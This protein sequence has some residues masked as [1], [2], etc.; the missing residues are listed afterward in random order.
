MRIF[1]KKA[2]RRGLK[3]LAVVLLAVSTG[4]VVLEPMEPAFAQSGA[5]SGDNSRSFNPFRPLLRLFGGGRDHRARKKASKPVR[6]VSRPAETPP[7]FAAEPKDPDAGVILVVGDRMARGVGGGLK[8]LLGD[9]PMVRVELLTEDRKGLAG[10]DAPDWDAQ[11]LAKIRGEDVK[12]VVVMMGQHDLGQKFPGDPPV[13]F[14]T[15]AWIGTYRKKVGD[16]VRTVRQERKPLVWVGL[17]P[18]NAE[19][20]NTDFSQLN[21]IFKDELS[22]SRTWYV[23]IWD[24]FLNEEGGYSSYGPNVDGKNARLRSGDKIGFTWAGYQ[25][26]A[27]FVERELSRILGGYGGYAFEG[28]DDDPDFIVLTGRVTSP[29]DELLGGKDQSPDLKDDS[30]AYRFFVRGESLPE[31]PGRVDDTKRAVPGGS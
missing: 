25:K 10:E 29:E 31:I 22:D 3:C 4:L 13:E 15:D 6:R 11:L 17:P 16:L 30:V 20:T 8:F 24:I 1:G 21:G 23:D 18:T 19:M 9:K 27:F 26:V 5:R 28:V 12:A 2:L 7:S 14:L